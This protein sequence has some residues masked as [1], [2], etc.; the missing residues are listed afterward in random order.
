MVAVR[1]ASRTVYD[2]SSGTDPVACPVTLDS[3]ETRGLPSTSRQMSSGCLLRDIVESGMERAINATAITIQMVG[4]PAASI[5]AWVMGRKK[6][7]PMPR[8]VVARDKAS[9]IFRWNH[10]AKGTEVMMLWGQ[11][12]RSYRQGQTGQ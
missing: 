3:T 4:Q 1:N 9:P 2:I 6:T 11:P 5:S 7:P 10:L 8:Q 12:T